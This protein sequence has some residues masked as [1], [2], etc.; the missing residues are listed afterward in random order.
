MRPEK[1][2]AVGS[3][4]GRTAPWT[5]VP[6]TVVVQVPPETIER[7]KRQPSLWLR[8]WTLAKV[9]GP[10][11][12]AV[13]ALVISLFSYSNEH[14]AYED[15]YAANQRQHRANLAATAASEQRQAELIS[16]WQV[17]TGHSWRLTIENRSAE[18]ISAIFTAYPSDAV[19]SESF[20]G[21]PKLYLTVHLV[22]PC[23]IAVAYPWAQGMKAAERDIHIDK[24]SLS[25]RERFFAPFMEYKTTVGMFVSEALPGVHVK[26][27]NWSEDTYYSR[28]AKA[29]E[30]SVAFKP[31]EGCS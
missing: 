8:L 17:G 15:Q 12:V 13:A 22:P 18:P 31:A 1:R 3:S 11:L 30:F 10:A 19:E 6:P 23:S 4:K 25:G 27:L 26:K 20:P 7:V 16:F 21:L 5:R 2:Y 24:A 29:V 28:M 14:A 9:I